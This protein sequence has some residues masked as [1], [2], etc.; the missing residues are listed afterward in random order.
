VGTGEHIELA[1]QGYLSTS[2]LCTGIFVRAV[3]PLTLAHE[4]CALP[5]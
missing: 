1:K 2:G 3:L 4:R 5:S